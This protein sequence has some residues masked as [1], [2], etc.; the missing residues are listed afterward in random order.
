MTTDILT[1]NNVTITGKPDAAGTVL[2]VNGLG[3]DQQ[4][5]RHLTPAFADKYRLVLFDHVGAIAGNQAYFREHQCHYLNVSGYADDLLEICSAL[6]LGTNTLLIGHS[7]GAMAGLLAAIQRPRQFNRLVLIGASPR[8]ANA[9]GYHGGFSKEDIAATYAALNRN[10]GEWSKQLAAA[11]MSNNPAHLSLTDAFA[12]S[13]AR[14]PQEIMLM[15]LCSI[16]QTDHRADLARVSVPTLLIQSSEDFFV[17]L[18]V[19]ELIRTSIPDCHLTVIPAK[20]HLP[21][22]SAPD[23]VAA[24]IHQFLAVAPQKQVAH[25]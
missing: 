15:V 4:F 19:A 21:H 2:F 13:L 20:G 23:E 12:Q 1:R 14:V 18:S 24:A 16:L 8:Y 25:H 17:P 6:N 10:Y 3:Y 22:V 7:M 5:W 11:T 9:D